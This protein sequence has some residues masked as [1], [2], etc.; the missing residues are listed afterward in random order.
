MSLPIAT[1][2]SGID[3]LEVLRQNLAIARGF[4]PMQAK[5]MQP[6]SLMPM[7]AESNM[8]FHLKAKCQHEM[9]EMSGQRDKGTS[10]P[11]APCPISKI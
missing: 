2:V 3:S 8:A 4:Q 9:R 5:E 6:S 1:L 7:K 10:K 11:N